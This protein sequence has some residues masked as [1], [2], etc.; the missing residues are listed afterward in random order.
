M[1]LKKRISV[2]INLGEGEYG[3]DLGPDVV[4][5]G[6]RCSA[7][8]T[9]VCV[10]GQGALSMRIY[11]IPPL[12]MNKLSTLG[13]PQGT[14]R[15]NRV[16]VSAGDDQTGISQIFT[17][18]IYN[19]YADY[20]A[21]PNVSLAIEAQAGF[22]E[23]INPIPDNS[24]RSGQVETLIE[25]LASKIGWTFINSGVSAA[26][27]AFH[28][29]GSVIDQIK[30][31][32][33]AANIACVFENDCVTIWPNGNE[34]KGD[35]ITLSP[36]SGMVG[37]PAFSGGGIIVRHL[38]DNRIKI[39]QKVQ[40]NTSVPQANGEFFVHAMQHQISAETPG[41]PWITT[42]FMNSSRF[43]IPRNV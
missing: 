14:A 15:R 12:V 23:Q 39:G 5:D 37:Y 9:G 32:A 10:C 36:Q 30:Q 34:V 8:I 19:A 20:S 27:G 38:F 22:Y 25:S 28:I 13:V 26:L 29:F 7:E 18:T 31:L 24:G 11:G 4:L 21:Q 1:P 41:G 17:G 16:I 2:R 42:V 35:D 40:V 33:S 6:Y 3:A 43:F